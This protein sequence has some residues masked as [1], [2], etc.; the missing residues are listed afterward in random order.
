MKIGFIGQ[1][2]IGSAY[3][4]DF[5]SRGFEVVRFALEAPYNKNEKEIVECDVVFIA[6]PTPTTPDGFS[7]D[8]VKDVLKYV[9]KEKVAVIKS[10]ILPG[11]TD[12]LQ[13]EFPH[14][15]LMHSPEFLVAATAKRDAMKPNRNVVGYTKRS[16]CKAKSI[17]DILPEAPF[18]K[19][20]PVKEAE[21]VKYMGNIFLAQKVLLANLMHDAAKKVGADYDIVKDVV[22]AD[23]R[24]QIGH[25][26][27]SHD[28]G[29]GAGGYCFIKDLSAFSDYY[30]EIFP[31]DLKGISIFESLEEKNI[32]LLKDSKKDIDLLEGVYGKDAGK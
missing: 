9:G 28:G 16:K 15:Y 1:G 25:L 11:T 26:D 21:L 19:T 2:F 18:N 24:I 22:G 27:I 29:R 6:V 13:E 23:P 10:T 12:K 30:K 31:E 17:L 32:Q 14:I 8:I 5:E 3:A 20:I 7:A 4:E